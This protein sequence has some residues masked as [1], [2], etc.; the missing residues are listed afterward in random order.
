M[1]AKLGNTH[2][3]GHVALQPCF[4]Q[5]WSMRNNR[6]TLYVASLGC[7]KAQVDAEAAIAQSQR[8][9]YRLVD[10]PEGAD[11]VVVN[12]CGFIEPAVRESL[13]TILDLAALKDA[14]RIGE[15]VVAGC[16]VD[17]YGA[18]LEAELPEVDRFVTSGAFRTWAERRAKRTVL[19]SPGPA[20]PTAADGRVLLNA[21]HYAYVKIAEGC[22]RACAFCTIPAIRGKQSS[23]DLDDVVTELAALQ[24]RGVVE[25]VLVS[26]DTVRWGLDLRPRRRLV[27]L[28]EA[29]E[30]A[31]TAPPWVRLHYLYPER[32]DPALI[33][34]LTR[35]TR[36]VPYVDVP[37][38]HG[39]DTVLAAMRRAHRRADIEHLIDT[40]RSA[41]PD[42]AI[43]T[44]IIV[45]HPGEDDNAFEELL[46]L[47]QAARFD[48]VGI[49]TYWDEEGT[50][51][52]AM[53]GHVPEAVK[54][55]RAAIAD[56]LARDV[57]EAAAAARV[58]TTLDVLTDG[59]DPAD[60]RTWIG[61]HKGQAPDV[62]SV[63]KLPGYRGP[64]GRIVRAH[65]V[66][67]DGLDLVGHVQDAATLN[68]LRNTP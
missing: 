16:L 1:L 37:I 54:A 55:E 26:Q 67:H 52:H 50:V 41:N 34:A 64:A 18:D 62:D 22:D 46:D 68:V 6:L 63:V 45:G 35:G 49:F 5:P 42:I 47:L 40:L 59:L 57:A 17:R 39:S 48:A 9:G 43:R 44:T 4:R 60:G 27:D 61:R 11:L 3:R 24:A 66:D 13:D 19:A 53:S 23:R 65:I 58:G 36:I 31:E 56:E 38:Q 32:F 20:L 7:A 21:P 10:H 12:T 8:A 33:A 29:I 15:L 25:A 30:T 28:V 2:G 14:G 51:S